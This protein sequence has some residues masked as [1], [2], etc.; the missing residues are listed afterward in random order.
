MTTVLD[1][2]AAVRVLARG[3]L[4]ALPTDT[5]YGVG[6][7]IRHPDAVRA[8][9]RLK[10]RPDSVPLPILVD[11]LTQIERLSVPWPDIA[12]RLSV[13]YWPGPLTIVV[14]VP[15]SLAAL[16]GSANATAGFRIADDA[17]LR[18]ILARTGPLALSSANEHGEAP[19]HSAA[20][21]VHAFAGRD[22]LEGV[23]D[24]GERMDR[25]STV[26]DLSE[27]P[28]RLVR[29]GAVSSVD[30]HHMLD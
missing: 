14:R 15:E 25:V 16:I 7:S 11:D 6:A 1:P 12:R 13:V 10:H 22:E 24:G 18:D 5:V 4:V 8:L 26:V 28:W 9:F 23:V 20:E 3:G 2:D 29:E 27:T 30:L 19:C 21:V 17:V